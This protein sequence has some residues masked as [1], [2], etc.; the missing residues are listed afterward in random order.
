MC[1]CAPVKV[2][3]YVVDCAEV[4]P[5]KH[6]AA[7]VYKVMEPFMI[8]TNER[9]VKNERAFFA[10]LIVNKLG[11]VCESSATISTYDCT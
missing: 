6:S 10:S 7:K 5:S 4:K 9:Q 11:F 1:A 8:C 2:R 3:L